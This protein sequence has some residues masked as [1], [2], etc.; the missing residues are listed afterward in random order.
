MKLSWAGRLQRAS[1]SLGP[2]I[3]IKHPLFAK[4]YSEQDREDPCLGG[5]CGGR[6][7]E[8]GGEEEGKG[9]CR[10]RTFLLRDPGSSSHS[11]LRRHHP[12]VSCP[13]WGSFPFAVPSVLAV[14]SRFLDFH[15]PPYPPALSSPQPLRQSSHLALLCAS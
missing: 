7:K 11:C 1:P 5:A 12:S 2:P 8:K 14:L 6:F 4:Y 3:I 15:P 13:V 10:S 9:Y